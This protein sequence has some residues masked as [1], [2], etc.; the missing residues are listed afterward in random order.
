MLLTS[1]LNR[2]KFWIFLAGGAYWELRNATFLFFHLTIV[3]ERVNL[4]EFYWTM[5]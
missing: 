5:V 4:V 1:Y 3:S 2:P